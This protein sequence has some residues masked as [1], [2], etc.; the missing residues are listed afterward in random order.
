MNRDYFE[1]FNSPP[2]K[3]VHTIN[4]LISPS[5]KPIRVVSVYKVVIEEGGQDEDISKEKE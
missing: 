1:D 3:P 4:E 5:K 2:M